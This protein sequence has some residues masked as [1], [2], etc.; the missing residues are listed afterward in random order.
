MGVYDF[1]GTGWKFPVEADRISGKIMEASGEDK[2][3][4]SIGIILSTRPGERVMRPEFGC[5][6]YEY[7]FEIPDF[8]VRSEMEA[9]VKEALILWEPRIR[10]IEVRVKTPGRKE[11][12][13]CV[14]VEINYVVRS[15]NNPYNLVYPFYLEEGLRY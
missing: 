3:R 15:T 1:L 5:R 6:I 10:D 12:D 4:E 11:A 9:A 7:L 2:I 8:R 14:Q 13:H